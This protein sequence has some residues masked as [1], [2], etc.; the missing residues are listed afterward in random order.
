M[1]SAPHRYAPRRQVEHI[2]QTL[3]SLSFAETL[4]TTRLSVP[5]LE[6]CS[7]CFKVAIALVETAHHS[8]GSKQYERFR[9]HRIASTMSN[10]NSVEKQIVLATLMWNMRFNKSRILFTINKTSHSIRQIR[11]IMCCRSSNLTTVVCWMR[12]FRFIKKHFGNCPICAFAW[13]PKSKRISSFRIQLVLKI[14]PRSKRKFI[15]H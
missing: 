7:R 12:I 3:S 15:L 14:R 9:F 1:F 11:E 8:L 6:G 2:T 4:A 13:E 10:G 5:W